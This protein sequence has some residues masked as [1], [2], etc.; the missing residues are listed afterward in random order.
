MSQ[1]SKYKEY[2]KKVIWKTATNAKDFCKWNK[3]FGCLQFSRCKVTS[4]RHLFSVHAIIKEILL[5]QFEAGSV[6]HYKFSVRLNGK[7]DCNQQK[8]SEFIDSSHNVLFLCF[9]CQDD[10]DYCM[11]WE[12]ISFWCH[13]ILVE[14]LAS[15]YFASLKEFLFVHYSD[16][17]TNTT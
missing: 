10:F 7:Y 12:Q 5:I 17:D 2:L 13:L 1:C 9:T 8:D 16:K 4:R 6:H 3:V 14:L 15:K 11:H